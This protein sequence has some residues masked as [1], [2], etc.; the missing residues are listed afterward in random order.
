MTEA[1]SV[2]LSDDLGER[3]RAAAAEVDVSVGDFVEQVLATWL[4]EPEDTEEA[5][6]IEATLAAER[7]AHASNSWVPVRAGPAMVAVLGDG[8]RAAAA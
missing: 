6:S 1:V 7:E 2:V 3:V 4:L 8:P 5:P